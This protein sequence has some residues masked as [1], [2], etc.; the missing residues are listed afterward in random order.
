MPEKCHVHNCTHPVVAKCLCQTHYKRF[1]RHGDVEQT[2][3]KDWGDRDKHP[4]YRSW[5]GLKRYHLLDMQEDWKQDFWKFVSDVGEKPET[6]RAFRPDSSRP[7]G[8]D[9]F[10]WKERRA[11]TEDRK[12]YMREWHKKAR[13]A[14]KDYYFDK[15]LQKLYGVTLDWYNKKLK[16]QDGVCAICK[17][18]ETAV[19]HGKSIS[20]AVD[21]CHNTGSARGLLC[22]K[23]NRGLGMF[24][25]KIDTIE[26][27]VRYLRRSSDE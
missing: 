27:A 21:H 7:W 13:I 23:C 8:A 17:E 3:P 24:R 10:Y 1:Q 15:D 19:I 9:N 25:D 2:R 6:G 22:T 26:S 14:N 12:E 11:T 16:E 20:L 4:A 18:P 5:C